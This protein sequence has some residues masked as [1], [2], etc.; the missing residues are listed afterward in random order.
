[1]TTHGEVLRLLVTEPACID[2]AVNRLEELSGENGDAHRL[3]DLAGAYYIRAHTDDRTSDLVRALD[4]ARRAVNVNAALPAAQFNLALAAE[5]LG[6]TNDAKT[7]W[8]KASNLDQTEWAAEARDRLVALDRAA[9]REAGSQWSLNRRR[10]SLLIAAGDR[11]AIAQLIR[12]FPAA[13]QRYLIGELLVQWA[14][15]YGSRNYTEAKRGLHE[16]NVFAAELSATTTDPY[17]RDLLARITSA[18][19][20]GQAALAEGHAAFDQAI[21]LDRA[22][23]IAPAE[24][25]FTHARK[26]LRR[27][28]S[29]LWLLAELGRL[30]EVSRGAQNKHAAERDLETLEGES[31]ARGYWNILARARATR[32]NLL[33]VEGRY[34]DGLALYDAALDAY[35]RTNDEEGFANGHMRKAGIFRVLGQEDAALD[36]T[37]LARRYAGKLIDMAP[38]H[39]LAGETA[40][41]MLALGFPHIAFDYQSM[42]IDDLQREMATAADEQTKKGMRVNLAIALRAR[43]A[44]RVHLGQ[45][46]QARIE[47][48][49]AS[50]IA[51]EQSDAKIRNALRARI[52]EA[53]GEELLHSEPRRAVDAFTEALDSM[54]PVRYRTFRTIVLTQR[55][56]AYR[57]LGDQAAAKRD[58][59]AAIQELNTEEAELLAGRRRGQ[60]EGLWADYFSRFQETYDRLIH[61]LISEKRREEAFVYAEKARAYEPLKL[62]FELPVPQATLQAFDTKSVN[63]AALSSIQHALPI[64]TFVLEYQ[65]AE[66]ETNVWI[67]SHD[68]FDLRTLRVGRR[69]I[70]DWVHSLQ[71]AA[72]NGDV[73]GFERGLSDPYAAL[74]ASPLAVVA[75]MKYGTSSDRRLV[76]VPGRSMH[77]LP[78][79]ALRAGRRGPYL[80]QNCPISIAASATLYVRALESD[81]TLVERGGIP[82]ALLVG[83]PAFN[84][85]LELA[86]GL[87]RLSAAQK[88]AEDLGALYEPNSKVLIDKQATVPA[89]LAYAKKSAIIHVAGHAIVNRHAPFGTLLLMAPAN[90]HSG[91]LYAEELLVRL[92][93]D[94]ARL[95]VLAACGSA[96]GVPVGPEGLAPLVRP[97]I[98]AGVPGVVGS[99][100]TI[101][102]A[103]SREVLYEFHRQYRNGSD[104]ALALQRA[105]NRF[106]KERSGAIPALAWAPF[107]LVGHATSPF[108]HNDNHQQQ[109]AIR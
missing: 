77:G 93:L 67:V 92:E 73:N 42:F 8:W 75:G 68:D 43:A 47:L 80:I 23:E 66:D 19:P 97:V 18:E 26:I 15:A 53:R 104:A 3:S 100:W 6:F 60:G 21:D 2:A 76:I 5:S 96:G 34:L 87:D 65:V 105:Q 56:E 98:A 30:T 49:T 24:A 36:E 16:A 62:V 4:A 40:A 71:R 55:A 11:R 72:V 70:E 83:D 63:P 78:F 22:Y 79:A 45:Q 95:V 99:L 106:L 33:Q 31:L 102:D 54:G 38:R 88:E 103:A 10:F 39:V 37:F 29:P 48:D 109:E 108:A 7:A 81:R 14:S 35:R 32:A 41:T 12:P 59:A 20:A 69:A 1:M 85:G 86:R 17:A 51:A 27:A 57:L 28:G 90:G 91:L 101:K 107:Q 58:F 46:K 9:S 82:S 94:R 64:G 25:A 74:L 13:A 44:I 89:F 84:K 61:L 50:S 52:A